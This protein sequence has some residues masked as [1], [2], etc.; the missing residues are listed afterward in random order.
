MY[1]QEFRHQY[2]NELEK[3]LCCFASWT[4][5]DSC[6]GDKTHTEGSKMRRAEIGESEIKKSKLE[7]TTVGMTPYCEEYAEQRLKMES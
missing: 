6:E 7:Q 3:I 2:I 4:E 5:E 1:C